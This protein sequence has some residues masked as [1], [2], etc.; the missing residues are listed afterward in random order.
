M[1]VYNVINTKQ[2]RILST[3]KIEQPT[4]AWVGTARGRGM[5]RLQGA[6]PGAGSGHRRRYREQVWGWAQGVDAGTE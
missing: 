4:T 2:Q 6:G 1:W 5:D 3:L